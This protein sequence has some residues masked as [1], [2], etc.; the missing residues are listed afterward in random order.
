M[1][2]LTNYLRSLTPFG[3]VMIVTVTLL[4]ILALY[5]QFRKRRSTEK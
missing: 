2:E 5:S 4:I 1:P 3:W